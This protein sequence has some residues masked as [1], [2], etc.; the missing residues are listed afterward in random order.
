M[1]LPSVYIWTR[2]PISPRLPNSIMGSSNKRNL[3]PPQVAIRTY[4][5]KGRGPTLPLLGKFAATLVRIGKEITETVYMFKGRV[6]TALLSRLAAERM[7]LVEHHL[8]MTLC[9][10][11]QIL[12]CRCAK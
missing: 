1:A 2:R 4:S 10:P 9:T 11:L 5:G 8:D 12:R 6:V 7:G 3:Q